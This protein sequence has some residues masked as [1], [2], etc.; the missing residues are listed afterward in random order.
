MGRG[1]RRRSLSTSNLHR[2]RIEATLFV[3]AFL[4]MLGFSM[5][6]PDVQLRL[7]ALL[8]PLR[9]PATGWDWKGAVIGLV[10]SS[11]FIVQILVSSGWGRLSDRIGRKPV[12]VICTAVSA[13]SMGV[14]ALATNPAHIL[15]SRILAG[16]GAAN[17]AVAQAYI[18]DLAATGSK[19][20]A[21]GRIGAAISAGLV[22][23]PAIGG[24]LSDAG[25]NA[26]LGAVACGASAAGAL[27]A[28][29][30]LPSLPVTPRE[31]KP[32][33]N[34]DILRTVPGLTR[35]FVVI[36][37]GWF[38][39][40]T[41]EGTFGRLIHATLG[42]G[43]KE[44]GDVFSYESLLG[45]VVQGLLVGIV[46]KKFSSTA[47]LRVCYVLMGLG[48]ALFPYAP[49]L[50]AIFAA[51]TVYGIGTS[52]ANPTANALCS[53]LT[54]EER[55]GEMF[56]LLQSARSF[57]FMVGPLLGGAI[58]DAWHAGPYLLAMAVCVCAALAVPRIPQPEA[59][60]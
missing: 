21:M 37:I 13:A 60:T 43:T 56:G 22:A 1:Q 7:D 6:I 48:L 39:L 29:I 20:A 50:P 45:L 59:A 16:L 53:Q 11:M 47:V 49:S 12:V 4:D 40:A 5:L 32:K 33:G 27:L 18:A 54:P 19:V 55:Q 51:S 10:L 23:G 44:F 46:A 58:F 3:L 57:G 28:L 14:Y 36:V 42:L 2:V 30:V 25:G 9:D 24:R 26:L 17:I 31:S 35:V 41:L 15:L 34:L 38:A 8:P 52:I